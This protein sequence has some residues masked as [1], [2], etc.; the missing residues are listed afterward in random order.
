MENEIDWSSL[1]SFYNCTSED[2]IAKHEL[3][4]MFKDLMNLRDGLKN[5]T[6][7]DAA[8]FVEKYFSDVDVGGVSR[9]QI[10][11][12]S[13][14]KLCTAEKFNFSLLS[15]L[16]NSSG[17][18]RR[19]TSIEQACL[20]ME[21]DNALR[22]VVGD[23]DTEDKHQDPD[24]AM[25]SAV[26]FTTCEMCTDDFN[27]REVYGAGLP[28]EK[29]CPCTVRSCLQ[30]IRRGARVQIQAGR[31]PTCPG[32]RSIKEPCPNHLDSTLLALLYKNECSMC[33]IR[34]VAFVQSGC[35]LEHKFCASCLREKTLTQLQTMRRV[36]KCPRFSE[37]RYVFDEIAMR[38]A[39]GMYKRFPS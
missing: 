1:L 2:R 32:R 22:D 15:T 6:I 21:R 20:Q 8:Y 16:H 9:A 36:P 7:E 17:E 4:F 24:P 14:S 26:E 37:C 10:V 11:E 18:L 28:C 5:H 3:V 39:L 25:E 12:F 27:V 34:D 19:L 29:R 13:S 35:G 33:G 38:N 31:H 23:I 30:C